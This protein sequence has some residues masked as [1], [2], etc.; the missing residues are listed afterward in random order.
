[1][2]FIFDPKNMYQNVYSYIYI[3]DQRFLNLIV[4][5]N[6]KFL[7]KANVERGEMIKVM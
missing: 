5:T 4:C 2:N 6:Y 3:L 7:Q 1:M